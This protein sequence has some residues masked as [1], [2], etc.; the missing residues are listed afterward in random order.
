V[1]GV[2]LTGLVVNDGT[3]PRGAGAVVVEAG[4]SKKETVSIV[5]TGDTMLGYAAEPLVARHSLRWLLRGVTPVLDGDAV[6]VN[7]EGP[8]TARHEPFRP[9]QISYSVPRRAIGALRRV[10]VTALGLANNH[11]LDQGPGGLSDTIRHAQDGGLATFGAG[12]DASQ[13]ERPLIIRGRDVTV[14]VVALAKGYGGRVTAGAGQAGTIPLFTG[15]IRRGYE[16]A[17]QAGADWVVGYV[18]WGENY[19]PVLQQQRRDAAKFAAVGYDLVVG[20]G[21]HVIQRADKIGSTPVIYSLGNFVF[22]TLGEF[23]DRNGQGLVLKTEFGADGLEGLKLTCI[24]VDNER[25]EYQPRPCHARES[26]RVL[27]RLGVPVK[28]R[29]AEAT[30]AR[31]WW[32]ESKGA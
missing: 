29:G 30:I 6:V 27:G 14:G 2:I 22:G 24:V 5:W 9:D 15:S 19:Y 7:A 1:F 31:S 20:H 32:A 11:A 18:H 12:M 4:K 3:G 28:A 26:A 13:A 21:P 17:R 8:I 23:S 16:L 25:V 10:G